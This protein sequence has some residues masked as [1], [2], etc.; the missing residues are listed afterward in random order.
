MLEILFGLLGMFLEVCL[1]VFFE[2]VIEIAGSAVLDLLL[3]GIAEV[4]DT[5]QFQ[6]ALLA[7]IRFLF[8]R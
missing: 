4:F 8:T 5:S 7:R 1:E 2:A 3:R 6:N